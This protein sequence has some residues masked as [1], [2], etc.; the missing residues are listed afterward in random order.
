MAQQDSIALARRALDLDAVVRERA[1]LVH[2]ITNHV[3]MN[4]TAN[5]TLALGAQPVMAHAREELDE[6]QAFAASL[7][8]NIGT[9]DR[10]WIE[11]MRVAGQAAT[12]RAT[13]IVLDPVGAGATKLRTETARQLLAE[14]SVSV[15]RGNA[16]EVL[17][18]A[19]DAGKVRGVDSTA[20]SMD[21]VRV[22]QALAA[23]RKT[24]VAV[25]G[26]VDL[27]TD[28]TTT[29]EVENGHALMSRVT[30][31]GCAATTAIAAFLGAAKPEDRCF[32]AAA[33]LA[34]FGRA[35]EMAA[36]RAA[37]PGTFVPAFLDALYRIPQ[38]ARAGDLRIR[39]RA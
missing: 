17:A 22:A 34:V 18:V 13:P 38:E 39:L 36:E 25:T 23:E 12:R 7:V 10:E 9:L 26:I 37:G 3:V 32:A 20:D 31:T 29:Y 14:L 1:P 27:V 2:H 33:A 19:G 6:M 24:V 11:S 4:F 5:V 35:G 8:L 15:L 30:G 28:G 16:G 21:A